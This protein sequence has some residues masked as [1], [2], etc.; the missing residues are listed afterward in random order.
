MPFV[1][2]VIHIGT[3]RLRFGGIKAA[4]PAIRFFTLMDLHARILFELLVYNLFVLLR[5][6][7]LIIIYRVIHNS[8]FIP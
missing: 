8:V 4:A 7:V 3:I 5:Q 6:V 2:L 1:M